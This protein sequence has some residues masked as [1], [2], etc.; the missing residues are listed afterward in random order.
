LAV[1]GSPL[2]DEARCLHTFAPTPQCPL[3]DT[4]YTA[5]FSTRRGADVRAGP[6]AR[7]PPPAP[8]L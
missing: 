2:G 8:G 6:A 4:A 3:A 5:A 7:R 1:I